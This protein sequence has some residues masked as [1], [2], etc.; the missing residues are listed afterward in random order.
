MGIIVPLAI[1]IPISASVAR[2]KILP[3]ELRLLSW[4]LIFSG[5]SNLITSILAFNRV[6]NMP[7]MH[8]YTGIEFVVLAIFYGRILPGGAIRKY[9]HFIIA[10]FLLFCIIN[11]WCG[12]GM[13]TYNSYTKSLEALCLI[14]FTIS[15]FKRDLDESNG[16]LQ[17]RSA[18]TSIN[19]GLL[20]YFS[21]SFVLFTL[22]NIIATHHTLTIT[23][24]MI[25]AT[26][27]LIMYMLFSIALWKYKT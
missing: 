8:I 15:Y 23:L 24:W 19:A 25:H 27:L 2:Y 6:N 12:Q 10:G 13:H 20:I 14:I 11:A 5:V 7:A 1:I 17:A 21:G 4:Y 26:L 16:H 3:G 22:Y 18:I 9:Q